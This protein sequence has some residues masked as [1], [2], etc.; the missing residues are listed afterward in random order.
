MTKEADLTTPPYLLTE[1]AF[2]WLKI[3]EAVVIYSRLH[4][5]VIKAD[6]TTLDI[7]LDVFGYGLCDIRIMFNSNAPDDLSKAIPTLTIDFTPRLSREKIDDLKTSQRAPARLTRTFD[8]CYAY[9]NLEFELQLDYSDFRWRDSAT[10]NLFNT[11]VIVYLL[12]GECIPDITGDEDAS[13]ETCRSSKIELL[14]RQLNM[15][16]ARLGYRLRSKNNYWLNCCW[17]RTNHH[18]LASALN[19]SRESARSANNS[20]RWSA[21]LPTE[22]T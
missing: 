14:A 5:S 22:W 19:I 16:V 10:G 17:W 4:S 9:G 15:D 13:Q 18:H 20:T 12:S 8:A 11:A 6:K 2:S 1:A 7:E 21:A 3:K